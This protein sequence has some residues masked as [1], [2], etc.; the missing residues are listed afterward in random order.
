MGA[1]LSVEINTFFLIARRFAYLRRDALHPIVPKMV[2][3]SFYI[4]WILVRCVL[5]PYI[6]IIYVEKAGEVLEER[7]T[8][9]YSPEVAFM[10]VHFALC[11]L[12][13]KWTYDLFRPM[14]GNGKGEGK[15]M[16][17]GSGGEEDDDAAVERRR[18]KTA[19][20]GGISDG[21]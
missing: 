9:M 16:G 6:M 19:E 12:N 4:T 20:G 17:K 11:L 1:C 3:A 15:G 2:N 10:P 8:L 13:L 14:F 7:G 18:T 21:L 5:Y